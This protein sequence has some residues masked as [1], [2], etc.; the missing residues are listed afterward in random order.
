MNGCMDMLQYPDELDMILER[1]C[2]M[3]EAKIEAMP[4]TP[5][6]L[7]YLTLTKGMDS[8]M[9]DEQYERFYW[10]YLIRLVNAIIDKGMTPYIFGEGYNDSRMKYFEQ[11]PAGKTILHIEKTHDL[12]AFKTNLK[13]ICALT[14]AYP[15]TLLEQGTPEQC[16]DK[17]KEIFDIL[18]PDGGYL[19]D[20]DCSMENCKPEN[21]EALYGY[22]KDYAKY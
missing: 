13:G 10:K 20:T 18:G 11:L 3:Q 1:Q 8:F 6:T 7:W 2:Q 14:G 9:S 19:F 4:Y 22:I 15:V 5:D 12:K 21:L 17:F 16:V